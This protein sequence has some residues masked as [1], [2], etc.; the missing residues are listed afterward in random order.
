LIKRQIKN[1]KTLSRIFSGRAGGFFATA[2]NLIG[3]VIGIKSAPVTL[4]IEGVAIAEYLSLEIES[5]KGGDLILESFVS[6]PAFTI[7]RPDMTQ[8]FLAQANTPSGIMALKG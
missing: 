1:K 6:N 7:A 3:E 5:I 8:S 4:G 2:A